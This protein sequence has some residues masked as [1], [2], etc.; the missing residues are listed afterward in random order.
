MQNKKISRV[1][2]IDSITSEYGSSRCSDDSEID[3]E[4]TDQDSYIERVIELATIAHKN[5]I[6]FE[7]NQG[8][9][10]EK[11]I[12]LSRTQLRKMEDEAILTKNRYIFAY[13]MLNE[14]FLHEK[15]PLHRAKSLFQEYYY[16][17]NFEESLS[18]YFESH[19]GYLQDYIDADTH[20]ALEKISLNKGFFEAKT[21]EAEKKDDS[22]SLKT[23]PS[24]V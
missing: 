5:S 11:I 20:A 24:S 8:A 12:K 10:E 17:D 13:Q 1:D 7:S 21:P 6:T 22:Q 19:Y 16:A 18:Q 4:L 23:S 15:D 9:V 14:K 3:A 2:S